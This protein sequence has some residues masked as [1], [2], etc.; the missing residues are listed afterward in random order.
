[1]T[2]VYASDWKDEDSA[3]RFFDAYRRILRSKWKHVQPIRKEQD[4]FS[5][6]CE[7]GYFELTRKGTQI[8]SEEGFAHPLH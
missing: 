2:L 1:M 3:V 7:D 4:R 5:G 8:L 6:K